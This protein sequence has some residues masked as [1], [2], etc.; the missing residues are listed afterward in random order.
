MKNFISLVLLLPVLA[1]SQKIES[2]DLGYST[3]YGYAQNY[4]DL[5]DYKTTVP[6]NIYVQQME[7]NDD[8]W[9]RF[10][11]TRYNGAEINVSLALNDTAEFYF[12][13]NLGVMI[14]VRN[15]FR[16]YSYDYVEIDTFS[17]FDYGELSV[18][19]N[20]E[21]RRGCYGVSL[22][23][24]ITTNEDRKFSFEIGAGA[25]YF[26]TFNSTLNYSRWEDLTLYSTTLVNGTDVETRTTLDLQNV[27]GNEQVENSTV[28]ELYMPIT[29]KYRLSKNIVFFR[30][31]RLFLT[32]SVGR[33][34]SFSSQL[35]SISSSRRNIKVGLAYAF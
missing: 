22:L 34:W 18:S 6:H 4:W 27:Y 26:N 5:N 15:E 8:G 12:K 33:E 23:P 21:I 3:N 14:G 25:K 13:L 10:N 17:N 9:Y 7:P 11:Q 31:L 16:H 19:Q 29:V 24:V 28:L 2:I 20:A 30:D 32:Y 35:N 1:F